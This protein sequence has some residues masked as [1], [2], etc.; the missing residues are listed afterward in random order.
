MKNRNNLKAICLS[1][2]LMACVSA[3]AQEARKK[4]LTIENL[5]Y[6]DTSL[7]VECED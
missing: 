5:T 4:V 6:P 3:A 1:A 2:M 7:L